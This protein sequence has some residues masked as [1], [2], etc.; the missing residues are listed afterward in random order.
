[1]SSQAQPPPGVDPTNFARRAIARSPE[2]HAALERVLAERRRRRGL[3][4]GG[5]G[6]SSSSSR[7]RSRSP[8]AGPSQERADLAQQRR[9]LERREREFEQQQRERLLRLQVQERDLQQRRRRQEQQLAERE[10]ELP[11][12]AQAQRVVGGLPEIDDDQALLA[13]P[14]AQRR[15]AILAPFGVTGG[16][17]RAKGKSKGAGW[18]KRGYR[19]DGGYMWINVK[20]GEECTKGH[21]VH[22]S[23]T[24]VEFV[25]DVQRSQEGSDYGYQARRG[26][27]TWDL[28][29]WKK[30]LRRL[31][32]DL[33][34]AGLE[35]KDVLARD[36]LDGGETVYY[37]L[38]DEEGTY[39]RHLY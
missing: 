13:L 5:S 9:A 24:L 4:G 31:L 18:H 34:E 10:R 28:L 23:S 15:S 20:E 1:M 39:V 7:A 29:F 19:D 30:S 2:E 25:R 17:R 33:E 36:L 35:E 16:R 12:R 37:R 11:A 32:A 21:D 14:V 26:T 8:G 6:G 27:M 38:Y 3:A 22:E